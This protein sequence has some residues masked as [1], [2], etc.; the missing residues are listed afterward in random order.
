[1]LLAGEW[2]RNPKF[3]KDEHLVDYATKLRR[4]MFDLR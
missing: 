4:I 2:V 1:V 3:E